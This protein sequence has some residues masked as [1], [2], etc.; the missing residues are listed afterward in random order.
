MQ[1]DAVE[2]KVNGQ[3]E[4]QVPPRVDVVCSLGAPKGSGSQIFLVLSLP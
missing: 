3:S 2:V 1:S 4:I